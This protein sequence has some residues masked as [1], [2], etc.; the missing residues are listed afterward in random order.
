MTV[1][2]IFTE[3]KFDFPFLQR[4]RVKEFEALISEEEIILLI[5]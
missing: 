2:T 3:L 4:S 1:S 5:S